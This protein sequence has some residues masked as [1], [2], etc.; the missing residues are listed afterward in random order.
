MRHADG[1]AAARRVEA[2][3]GFDATVTKGTDMRISRRMVWCALA[4]VL[5]ALVGYGVYY[6]MAP[7]PT[8]DTYSNDVGSVL[9]SA[10]G[11]TITATAPGQHMGGCQDNTGNDLAVSETS[12]TVELRVHTRTAPEGFGVCAPGLTAAPAALS[13]KLSSALW[14]RTLVGGNG[15]PL[16]YFDGR[17]MLTPRPVP[18]GYSLYKV[19]PGAGRT[20]SLDESAPGV[21]QDYTAGSAMLLIAQ[22][23]GTT[24]T[25]PDNAPVK[26]IVVRGHP[27]HLYTDRGSVG[28]EWTE[29]GQI[30]A[31]IYSDN[32]VPGS[33]QTDFAVAAAQS[34]R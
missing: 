5:I 10:D 32:Q 4:A 18:S 16:A 28:V 11:L 12:R 3:K 19:Y 29:G 20:L 31:V 14:G 30:V 9:V 34:L 15:R 26:D 8:L 17:T 27:A 13:V 25:A 6:W 33:A 23:V 2:Q 22:Q 1:A 21:V 24:W 7:A